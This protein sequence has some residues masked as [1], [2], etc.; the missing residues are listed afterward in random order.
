MGVIAM[1]WERYLWPTIVGG[2][3]TLVQIAPIKI[4]PW[5]WFFGLL[6]RGLQWLIL[7]DF[8]QE[9]KALREK[10][11]ALE[12]EQREQTAEN[13]RWMILD[14]GNSCMQGRRHTQNEWAHCL[15]VMKK[16]ENDCKKH[17]I[18]NGEIEQMTQYLRETDLEIKRNHNYL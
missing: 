9:I 5:S 16:Y 11:E 17:N 2:L 13:R 3:V 12:K 1:D 10:I 4:N 6:R 18:S 15:K 14:F 8:P 7:G